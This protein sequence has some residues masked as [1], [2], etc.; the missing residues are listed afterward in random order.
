MAETVGKGTENSAAALVRLK[1]E[2]SPTGLN[3]DA[4]ADFAFAAIDLG[5]RLIAAGKPDDAEKFFREAEKSL[6]LA[7]KKTPDTAARDKAQYL[8]KLALIRS[9]YLGKVPQAKAD[10][11]EAIRLQ[12]DDQHLRQTR[13]AVARD[14]AE[15][16]KDKAQPVGRN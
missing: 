10:L 15:H 3:L 5:R 2:P 6:D 8:Q 13:D 1:K 4:D 14:Q 11:A 9:Q 12:P 16:F 7:V